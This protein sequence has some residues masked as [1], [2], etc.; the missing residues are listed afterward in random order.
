MIDRRLDKRR[1]RFNRGR[2][3]PDRSATRLR[4][5]GSMNRR[6]INP[7]VRVIA[8]AV[9]VLLIV[10]TGPLWLRL[11]GQVVPDG[12]IMAYAPARL[13]PVMLGFDPQAQV[14]NPA[15]AAAVDAES[16]LV[17]TPTQ[18]PSPTPTV[19]PDILNNPD[20]YPDDYVQP[21]PVAIAPTPTVTPAA[22]LPVDQRAADIEN[23]SDLTTVQALLTGFDWEQQGINNCGPASLKTLL[24]YWGESFTEDEA[25]AFLK[26]TGSDPNVRPDE[27]ANYAATLGYETT[28]R[29]NGTR[30]MMQRFIDAEYP[31]MIETGYNPEPDTIGWTSHYLTLVGYSPEGFIAMDTYR[32]PNWFYP[33]AEIE[34]YWRQFNRKVLIFHR[35]EQRAAVES[36]ILADLRRNGL[37][38][39]LSDEA[40]YEAAKLRAQSELLIN[41]EDPYAWY[42]LGASL[43]GLGQY[44]DAVS[45]FTEARRL[46]LPERF[47][48]YQFEMYEAYLQ[49]GA[50]Q[51]VIT[52]AEAVLLRRQTEEAHYYMGLA[53]AA[54]GDLDGARTQLSRALAFNPNY[55]DAQ[56]ALD[57]LGEE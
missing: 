55:E 11:L 7:A 1:R 20:A 53:L 49:V 40:M 48:W 50:T 25:A 21:T 30:E 19:D 17:I 31:V 52:I 39:S 4:S 47:P 9:V 35:P 12:Y 24:S 46:G 23:A 8:A 33:Y 43:T 28:I 10:V 41:R 37:E 6:Q 45:A 34:Q 57:A 44:A 22:A 3:R 14:P 54:E 26:P 32:R 56:L 15:A 29:V 36:I 2:S 16:L 27:M 38:E 5:Y 18:T 51:E 42:N 13:Q